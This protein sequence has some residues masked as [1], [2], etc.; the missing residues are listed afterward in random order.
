MAED[1]LAFARSAGGS[2][3]AVTSRRTGEAATAAFKAVL[4]EAGVHEWRPGRRENPYLGY[5]TLADVLVVTGDSES[6]LG[7]AAATDKPLYIYPVPKWRYGLRRVLNEW[8]VKRAFAR[9]L[10]RRGTIRPQ[11]GL[12]YLFAKGIATGLLPPPRDLEA[13]HRNLVQHGIA[14]LF[15]APLD[16]TPRAPLHETDAVAREILRRMGY[17][18]PDP[19]PASAHNAPANREGGRR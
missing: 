19:Q 13:L 2:A 16:L 17:P 5:L 9:P 12:E 7:E 11:Q 14:R 6:M 10:N 4:G 15:G 1:V 3:I 18:D 8:A